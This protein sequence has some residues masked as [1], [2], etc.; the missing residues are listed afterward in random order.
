VSKQGFQDADF[1][2]EFESWCG[3]S[4]KSEIRKIKPNLLLGPLCGRTQYGVLSHGTWG[5]SVMV[6][7][8]IGWP[9]HAYWERAYW[10]EHTPEEA[11][12]EALE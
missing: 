11:L 3:H 8:R 12:K 10:T 2:A 6:I 5:D 9:G 1:D 7:R 4:I